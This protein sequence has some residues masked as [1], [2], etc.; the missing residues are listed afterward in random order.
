VIF[1]V[2][3]LTGVLLI[4]SFIDPDLFIN[5]EITPGMTVLSYTGIFVPILAICRAI[6]PEDHMIYNPETRLQK[7]VEHTH[8]SPSEWKEKLHSDEVNDNNYYNNIDIYFSIL[9]LTLFYFFRFEKNCCNY[10]MVKRPF[11]FR[12]SL[13]LS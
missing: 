4:A 9:T 6:I 2:G 5:F 10:L 11:S 7:V 13:V 3:S 1:I 8:Y 12:K